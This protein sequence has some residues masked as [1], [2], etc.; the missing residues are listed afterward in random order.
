[1]HAAKIAQAG[2]RL[3]ERGIPHRNS[4][5]QLMNTTKS[6]HFRRS[7]MSHRID[8]RLSFVR[9]LLMVLALLSALGNV[10]SAAGDSALLRIHYPAGGHSVTVR[11]SAGGLSWTV[12]QPTAASGDT[13]TYTLVGLTAPAEWKPLLDDA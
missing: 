9:C 10:C 5:D 11:G 1:M 13:F 8:V 3:E 6:P 2:L 4:N 7:N 12:G